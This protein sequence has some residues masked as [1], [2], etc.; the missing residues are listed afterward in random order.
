MHAM[1]AAGLAHRAT[2]LWE[3]WQDTPFNPACGNTALHVPHAPEELA[4]HYDLTISHPAVEMDAF[5]A[6][7]HWLA[8]EASGRGLS[9]GLLHD[10]VVHEAVHR[11][12]RGQLTIGF[13]LDYFSLWHV[14]DDPYA[15]LAC[16]VQDSGGQPVNPPARARTF[17]DKAAS[18]G[19]LL[20]RGLGVPATVIIRPWIPDR[21]LT[22]AERTYLRLDEPAARVFI[23]PA[24]GCGGR[25]I[26]RCD[27]TDPDSLLAALAAARN[28]DRSD[29]FLIQREVRTPRLMCEDGVA[30][31]AYWRVLYCLRELFPF[32]WSHDETVVGRP[33]YRRLTSAEIKQ[34]H[35]EPVLAFVF[36]LADLSGLQWFSTELCLSAGPEKSRHIV[37]GSGDSLGIYPSL[38][39]WPVLAVDYINDQCD[40][41]V[42]GRWPGAPPDDVVRRLAQRFAEAAGQ[43]REG[44]N[45]RPAPL[46]A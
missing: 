34:H 45:R 7:D 46:A 20:R 23:K 1:S 24:N 44:R 21:L 4:A 14:P 16:A 40:V 31:L 15:R 38:T 26:V 29:A 39:S 42:Q 13:H 8:E 32:W 25:G 33:S 27:Q 41:D 12:D 43:V 30:R 10:R 11:L 2:A 18:H 28:H 35:L 36:D 9:C 6:F 5:R 19:E 37:W 17:T 3:E 22:S